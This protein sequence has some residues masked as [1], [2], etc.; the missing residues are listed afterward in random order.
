MNKVRMCGEVWIQGRSL[1]KR[2]G[3][4]PVAFLSKVSLRTELPKISLRLPDLRC[5]LVMLSRGASVAVFRAA[6]FALTL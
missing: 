2:G 3:G 5:A 4:R 1:M 6:S